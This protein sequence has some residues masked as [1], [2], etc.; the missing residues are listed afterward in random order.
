MRRGGRG[1]FCGFCFLLIEIIAKRKKSHCHL[2]VKESKGLKDSRKKSRFS[3]FQ[4]F[5]RA[6][7]VNL[8]SNTI[9]N[10]HL[11]VLRTIDSTTTFTM[12]KKSDSY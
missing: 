5:G 8:I 3:G 4:L 11:L 7:E 12:T 1:T 2:G 9:E 10:L 6:F